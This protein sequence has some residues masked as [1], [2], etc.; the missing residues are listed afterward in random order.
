M[1][2]MFGMILNISKE[3]CNSL[4]EYTEMSITI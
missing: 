4:K 1:Y 2:K 3:K